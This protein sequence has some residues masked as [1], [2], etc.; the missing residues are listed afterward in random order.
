[1]SNWVRGLR[2][3]LTDGCLFENLYSPY[4]PNGSIIKKR[5]INVKK[6]LTKQ[7]EYVHAI[8]Q[9]TKGV[10]FKLCMQIACGNMW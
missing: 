9:D 2:G 1:M 8:S 3:W 7:R 6:N 10:N 4:R 5:I